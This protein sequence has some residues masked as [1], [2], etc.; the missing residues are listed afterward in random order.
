MSSSS[1]IQRYTELALAKQP[2][3][4][5][6]LVDAHGSTPQDAGSKMIVTP[7]GLD[8]GTVGGGRVEA[9]AI[10]EALQLMRDAGRTKFVDWSLKADVGMT[11][12]GRVRLYFESVNVN[13]WPIVV[14]GAGHVTQALAKLLSELPCALTCIDPRA[15][16]LSR[17]PESV[18]TVCTEA[19]AEEVAGLPDGAYVLC[20]TKGH[21]SDFPVLQAIFEQGWAF[22]FLGV[23]GSNAKAA[24]LRR[25]LQ[26]VGI[27]ADRLQFHC[28]VGLPIGSNH[29]AEI[30]VSIAA[31]LLKE[32]DASRQPVEG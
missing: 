6:T 22:P 18:V 19:P 14:F 15:D 30:A 32:R 29:P 24:V 12:G 9:K 31:Q 17:L 2:F 27:D 5:V 23:I 4:A 26:D 11:C 28:P 10:D 1:H 3:V 8:H 16:W 13:V 7:S 20:M 25:E 21:R